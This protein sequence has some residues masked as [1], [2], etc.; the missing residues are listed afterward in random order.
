MSDFFERISHPGLIDIALDWGGLQVS[1][2]FPGLTPD[3][4]VGRPVVLTGRF[5][6]E[7][8]TPIR[9]TGKVANE[10]FDFKHA[11]GPGNHRRT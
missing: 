4:F 5:Q 9:I 8:T 2:V 6:G 3:L 10:R 1:E 7:T 11:R